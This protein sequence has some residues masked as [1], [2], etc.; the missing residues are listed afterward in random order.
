MKD[1]VKERDGKGKSQTQKQDRE[2]TPAQNLPENDTS[3]SLD[4]RKQAYLDR[5]QK[6]REK[7]TT[8]KIQEQ[9]TEKQSY[10]DLPENDTS[11]SKEER[12]EAY[13]ERTKQEADISPD[14]GKDRGRE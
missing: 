8:E 6:E 9:K 10:E 3:L 12:K 13:I 1:A 4:V 7:D 2:D 14:D 11:L 5:V